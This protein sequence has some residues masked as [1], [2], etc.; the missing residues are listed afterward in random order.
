MIRR[1]TGPRP[2]LGGPPPRRHKSGAHTPPAVGVTRPRVS[3]AASSRT[4]SAPLP[5]TCH[6]RSPKTTKHDSIPEAAAHA[7]GLTKCPFCDAHI[8]FLPISS[9]LR[10]PLETHLTR[11]SACGARRAGTEWA[12]EKTLQQHIARLRSTLPVGSPAHRFMQEHEARR[13]VLGAGESPASPATTGSNDPAAPAADT[14]TDSHDR[15]DE[16]TRLEDFSWDWLDDVSLDVIARLCI[17]VDQTPP[18]GVASGEYGRM[19]FDV[20][21]LST[22]F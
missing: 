21:V 9:Q 8:C 4:L 10:C 17:Y 19:M 3:V 20:T 22:L 2:P 5:H 16:M 18:R 13:R 12:A 7:Q 6:L 11:N 15:C 14:P 1:M